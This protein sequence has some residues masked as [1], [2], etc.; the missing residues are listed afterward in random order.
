M[1]I[2]FCRFDDQKIKMQ[3]HY[4]YIIIGTGAG[5]GTIAYTLAESGK[6]ILILERGR[7]LPQEK[8]NWDTVAVF[9]EER[10]HTK[11]VWK[12][13]EGEDLHPGTGYWVGG[14]T[15]VYGSAL[16]RL[17]AE[18]FN[19]IKHFGGI[20]PSWPLKYE[21]FEPFYNK[22]E[23]L[24]DVHGKAGIDPTEPFRSQ[25]L[26]FD[27]VADEPRISEVR[28]GLEKMGLHP[29]D[30]PLGLKLDEKN[31][32]K[33]KCIKCDTCDG[34]PCLLHAKADSDINCIRP[35]MDLENITLLINTQ[36]EK[37]LTNEEGNKIIG[38][39]T[40]VEG[41][42]VTFSGETVIVSCGAVN[43]A[44]LFLKSANEKHPNGLANKSDQVGRNFMKHQN[45][46]MLAISFKENPV[47]FQKTIAINDYYLANENNE[48]FKFPMGGIQ[49]MGKS[50]RYMLSGDAPAF[51]PAKV[52]S[53]MAQHSVD[54]WFMAEDLPMPENR[55]L[56]QNDQIHLNYTTHNGAA[57][58][59]LL[60]TFSKV[61]TEMEDHIKFLPE[62]INI[63][64]KIPL[65][66]VAH[67][68]GTLRFGN[69]P[70]TSVLDANCK[71]HEIDNLYVVDA[72]FFPS[73]GAVNPSLTIIANAIRVGEHLIKRQ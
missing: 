18:D 56:W 20:S 22:A 29:F 13:K 70:L 38:V 43:S 14:N 50:N 11:E 44:I 5:G 3:L 55:V 4:D 17:R 36:A 69:D 21:D 68:N 10:Y 59:E 45:A 1:L 16:F 42:K 61:L 28:A 24:Y 35:I 46:A 19:E 30:I 26:P 57:L 63:S 73:C 15:K 67:Q 54:W 32:L 72:S 34:F 47:H 51:T 71:T 12:D 48:D 62:N 8:E 37:L 25:P 33:S 27:G 66:G 2:A 53:E 23:R 9:Q 60:K 6:S 40:L 65:A 49:L 58:D 52:L 64:K 41:E 39:E 7:F 31:P